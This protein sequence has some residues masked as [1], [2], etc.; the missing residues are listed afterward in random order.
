MCRNW[1]PARRRID[2]PAAPVHHADHES[3]WLFLPN[4]RTASRRPCA[5]AAALRLA[6]AATA[7]TARRSGCTDSRPGLTAGTP[8]IATVASDVDVAAADDEDRRSQ[9]WGA[10]SG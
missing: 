2:A 10:P 6:S 1:P 8:P 7:G 4:P 3:V 9:A 5:P